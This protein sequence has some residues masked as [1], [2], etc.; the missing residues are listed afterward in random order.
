MLNYWEGRDGILDL[1][2]LS[3]TTQEELSSVQSG[4]GIDSETLLNKEQLSLVL[5]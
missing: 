3:S 1:E 2:I 5:S 4:P